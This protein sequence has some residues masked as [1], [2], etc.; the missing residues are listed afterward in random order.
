MSDSGDVDSIGCIGLALAVL[1]VVGAGAACAAATGAD[2]ADS[3]LPSKDALVVSVAA[4]GDAEISLVTAFN[5]SADAEKRA[6]RRFERN[7]TKRTHLREEFAG[8][9]RNV[10]AAADDRT[11]RDMGAADATVRVTTADGGR[12]G[13]VAVS[14]TWTNLA[15]ERDGSLVVEEPFASGFGTE[16]AFVL[17]APDGYAFADATPTPDANRDGAT[18]WTA[19]SSLDGFRAVMAPAGPDG[20]VRT[21]SGGE[22]DG[23]SESVPGLGVVATVVALVA[24]AVLAARR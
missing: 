12:T 4:D 21:T 16:R 2:A 9:L 1:L 7:E 11:E 6:F 18:T 22:T 14:V 3:S 8:S 5:L 17:R 19:S 23:A 10:I 20:S 15:A 24:I 13:V